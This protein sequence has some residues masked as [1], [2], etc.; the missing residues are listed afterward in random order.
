MEI[1]DELAAAPTDGQLLSLIDQPGPT[2]GEQES[3]QGQDELAKPSRYRQSRFRSTPLIEATARLDAVEARLA[4]V[5]K[6]AG[7]LRASHNRKFA[8]TVR[9]S[10]PLEQSPGGPPPEG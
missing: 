7:F 5:E 2:G 10:S 3:D 1:I 8:S 4:A 9:P 6:T